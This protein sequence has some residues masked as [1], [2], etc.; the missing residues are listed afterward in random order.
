MLR[1][2]P[3]QNGI[4]SRVATVNRFNASIIWETRGMA[5]ISTNIGTNGRWMKRERFLQNWGSAAR[6]GSC[7]IR[8]GGSDIGRSRFSFVPGRLL[9]TA[10]HR[11]V[12]RIAALVGDFRPTSS[13]G[14]P[15][16][17]RAQGA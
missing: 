5:A 4:A 10:H 2:I 13:G 17:K 14:S 16:I 15:A 3:G 9:F 11:G 1:S 6:F 7:L 8:G 12:R